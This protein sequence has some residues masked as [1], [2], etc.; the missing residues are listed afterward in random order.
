M[1]TEYGVPNTEHS[2]RITKARKYE[3]TNARQEAT[4]P[5]NVFFR[6]FVL[7]VFRD[8]EVWLL[9]GAILTAV[10]GNNPRFQPYSKLITTDTM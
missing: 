6:V 1:S 9:N 4:P 2:R 7:S 3:I 10:N 8:D 5:I